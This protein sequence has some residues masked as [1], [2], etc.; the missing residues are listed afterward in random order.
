MTYALR[1]ARSPSAHALAAPIARLIALMALVALGL[2][3]VPFHDPFHARSPL[4]PSFC[5][6]A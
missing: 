5:Y 1:E 2:S 4:P 6:C 3:G